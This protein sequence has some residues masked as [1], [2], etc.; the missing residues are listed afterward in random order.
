MD[1][2]DAPFR[3]AHQ[4]A[5]AMTRLAETGYTVAGFDSIMQCSR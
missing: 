2:V 1:L 5:E 4:D 3:W